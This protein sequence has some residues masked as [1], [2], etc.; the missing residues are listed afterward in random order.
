MTE[1]LS[2]Q[3]IRALTDAALRARQKAYAPYSKFYVGAAVL[4]RDNSIF[5]AGNIENANYGDTMCAESVAVT[6]ALASGNREF[7]AVAIASASFPP[8]LMNGHCCQLLTEFTKD[9]PIFLINVEGEIVRT[10]LKRLYPREID[11]VQI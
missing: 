11:L 7:A 3:Q 2:D 10:S 6:A 4:M 9:L 1:T 5:T 8:V